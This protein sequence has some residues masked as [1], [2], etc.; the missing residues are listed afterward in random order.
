MHFYVGPF[1][2]ANQ[3]F[4]M[5]EDGGSSSKDAGLLLALRRTCRQIY[6]ETTGMWFALNNFHGR[7]DAITA[8]VAHPNTKNHHLHT[9]R[10][11]IDLVITKGGIPRFPIVLKK[12]V[13]DTIVSMRPLE[14]L[15]KIS[16]TVPKSATV[17]NHTEKAILVEVWRILNQ[18][19]SGPHA[20]FTFE[21]FDR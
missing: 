2:Y 14:N 3:V 4:E 10:L 17:D 20:E 11:R 18:E 1:N 15:K 6:H 5:A 8:F 16:F 21:F 7:P 9:V 12:D 19:R 13:H